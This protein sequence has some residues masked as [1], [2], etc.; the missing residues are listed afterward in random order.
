MQPK[1]KNQ[2]VIG[3]SGDKT[4]NDAD[5]LAAPAPP[6]PPGDGRRE[7]EAKP[8]A[9]GT[10]S[11]N[12]VPNNSTDYFLPLRW[13]VD[14]LY[15]SF[16]GRIRQDRYRENLGPSGYRVTNV[17]LAWPWELCHRSWQNRASPTI[18]AMASL[19]SST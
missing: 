2:P 10:P 18:S 9:A 3:G 11:T 19:L 5:A 8:E 12:R 7:A 1:Q 16:P 6:A 4:R 17:L 14:S 15:L 13:G